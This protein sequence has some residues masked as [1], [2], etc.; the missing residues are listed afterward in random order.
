MAEE[1]SNGGGPNA[2]GG[3]ELNATSG[4]PYHIGGMKMVRTWKPGIHESEPEDANNNDIRD[5]SP[6]QRI[7][8]R[9]G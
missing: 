9:K 1:R 4:P 3:V 5:R 7:N 2:R 6:P 8:R